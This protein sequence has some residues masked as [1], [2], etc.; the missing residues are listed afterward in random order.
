MLTRR[1]TQTKIAE[2]ARRPF[3]AKA[4]KL[5]RKTKGAARK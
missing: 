2:E 3:L 1:E 4:P 5:T